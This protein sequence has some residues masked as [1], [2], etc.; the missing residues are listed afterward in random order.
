MRVVIGSDHAG[1]EL[2]APIIAQLE[3]LGHSPLDVGTYSTTAV[4]YPDIARAV[5]G[6]IIDGKADIGILLCGSGVGGCV[7]VNKFP[8]IRGGLCHDTYSAHQGVE[9]DDVNVLCLGG[10]IVGRALAAEIVK[11]FLAARFSGL[12]RHR[13]RIEKINEIERQFGTAPAV[14]KASK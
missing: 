9:D 4:D 14:S 6:A 10:R 13:R 3:A 7:A 2:K 5:A 1:F 12:E 8:G 11:T